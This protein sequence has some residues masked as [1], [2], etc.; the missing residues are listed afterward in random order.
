[1]LCLQFVEDKLVSGSK[2][3]TIKVRTYMSMC[4]TGYILIVTI[5]SEQGNIMSSLPHIVTSV[6][7]E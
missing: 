1:M 4:I 3:T 7:H 5:E 2:D 6:K